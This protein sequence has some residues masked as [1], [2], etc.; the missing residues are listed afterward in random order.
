MSVVSKK[1]GNVLVV[2]PQGLDRDNLPE[3]EAALADHIGRG[4]TKIVLDLSG[5]QY[6]SSLGLRVILKTVTAMMQKNGRIGLSGGNDQVLNVL[7][8][9]GGM[10]M[11][12]HSPGLDEAVKKINA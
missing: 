4:E 1:S 6:I 2:A 12:L 3:V 9:S 7:R 10:V 11:A 8:L 5:V